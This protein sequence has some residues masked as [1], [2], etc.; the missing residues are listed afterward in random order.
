MGTNQSELWQILCPAIPPINSTP[1]YGFVNERLKAENRI[2]PRER[3]RLRSANQEKVNGYI[4]IEWP[5]RR[6]LKVKTGTCQTKV[7]SG[8]DFGKGRNQ[9]VWQEAGRI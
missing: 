2:Y 7:F 9:A 5:I 1:R 6:D 8:H 3:M 4:K